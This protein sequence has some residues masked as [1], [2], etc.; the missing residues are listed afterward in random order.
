MWFTSVMYA[1]QEGIKRD[2]VS[3]GDYDPY[4]WQQHAVKYSSRKLKDPI[5][6]DLEKM[7]EDRLGPQSDRGTI[8]RSRTKVMLDPTHFTKEKLVATPF[9]WHAQVCPRLRR[10]SMP[11]HL[12]VP[13]GFCL[14][15]SSLWGFTSSLSL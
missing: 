13:R 8:P 12:R 7:F 5:K 1:Q 9:G 10:S 2:E 14:M 6:R 15:L 4:A 3:T 11:F